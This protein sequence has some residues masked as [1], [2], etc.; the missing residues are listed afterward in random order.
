MRDLK[1][2]LFRESHFLGFDYK[3]HC[4]D[5]QY[6]KTFSPSAIE[7]KDILGFDEP[8]DTEYVKTFREYLVSEVS[9]EDTCEN[10]YNR[11]YKMLFAWDSYYNCYHYDDLFPN[12]VILDLLKDRSKQIRNSNQYIYDP[13]EAG[14]QHSLHVH[15]FSPD[16]ISFEKL[17]RDFKYPMIDRAFFNYI[18]KEVSLQKT[19]ADQY[20]LYHKLYD[21]YF[22]FRE[23]VTSDITG[24]TEEEMRKICYGNKK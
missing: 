24:L 18:R 13:D 7:A 5:M 23:N 2:F 14:R 4:I 15:N 21:G 19:S 3:N 17:S 12:E 9:K 6:I 8:E 22:N 1:S 11:Y 20:D 16:Y 10:R